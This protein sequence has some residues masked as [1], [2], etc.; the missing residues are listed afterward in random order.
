MRLSYMLTLECLGVPYIWGG[1]SPMIGLD[2][3]GFVQWVL[4][5]MDMLDINKDHTAQDIYNSL[6]EKCAISSRIKGDCVLFFGTDRFNITHVA[7]SIN[8]EWMAEAAH[9]DSH[10]I[11]KQ[12]A[13]DKMAR[14]EFN[15]I[16]RRKDLV[17]CLYLNSETIN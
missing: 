10:C 5:K 2:C 3:S 9:G 12:H 11:L 15:R 13:I 14:V 4:K 1:N 17:S 8:D 7:I 16:L 6:V